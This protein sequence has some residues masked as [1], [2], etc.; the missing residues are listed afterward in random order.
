LEVGRPSVLKSAA[1][2]YDGKGQARIEPDTDLVALWTA[3]QMDRAVVEAFVPFRAE[4]SVLVARN[5]SGQVE[6][7]PLAE[8]LHRRHILH[9]SIVPARFEPKVE[10]NA[11]RM[12]LALAETFQLEGLLAVEL[13]L[14]E[15]G[16]LLVNELAP[17]PHNSGHWSFDASLTS[18]F[19]QHIR[20]VAGLPLGATDILRPAVMTNLLGDCWA[21]TEPD[22]ESLLRNPQ[23]KLHL[24]DKG[25][26]RPG[27]KMGHFTVTGD[28]VN[29]AVDRADRIFRQL[30]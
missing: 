16:S 24:Y 23:V 12:A 13:F 10:Q 7:F 17:R 18:Q 26:A 5:P 4:C 15:D 22:W 11:R 21:Q 8:N 20:A 1:F 14:L 9:Q 3:C 27:R 6:T 2:G 19:E 25:E 28:S 30:T 29:E